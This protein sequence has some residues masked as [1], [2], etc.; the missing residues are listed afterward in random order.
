R[1]RGGVLDGFVSRLHYFSDWIYDNE[2]MGIVQ[3][4]TKQAGGQPYDVT[5]YLMSRI[6][7]N[8]RQLVADTTLIAPIRKIEE[9]ISSRKHYFIPKTAL[10]PSKIQDG[11]ILAMTTSGKGIEIMH[12]GFAVKREGKVYFMHASSTGKCV[13]ITEEPF[14]NYVRRIKSNKGFMIVRP[15]Y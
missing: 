6:S 9:E 13:M 5:A 14:V 12:M 4:I 11:D 10:K 15:V 1:Y 7:K 8:Y 3:D 2:K